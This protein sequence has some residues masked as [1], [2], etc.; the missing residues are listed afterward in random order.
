MFSEIKI[1]GCNW[2]KITL[3]V[4]PCYLE[5]SLAEVGWHCRISIYVLLCRT[6]A[7]SVTAVS[8]PRFA[9]R[10]RRLLDRG[11]IL[12]GIFLHDPGFITKACKMKLK[13]RID[14]LEKV[15][16]CWACNFCTSKLRGNGTRKSSSENKTGS[17][18]LPLREQNKVYF[19]ALLWCSCMEPSPS[20]TQRSSTDWQPV[21]ECDQ[22]GGNWECSVETLRHFSPLWHA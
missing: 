7:K 20:C 14:F 22:V 5:C 3:N 10:R 18:E 11:G 1:I 16:P 19:W 12:C 8:Q 9:G 13:L 17:A 15:L 2:E 6:L 4:V 21:T